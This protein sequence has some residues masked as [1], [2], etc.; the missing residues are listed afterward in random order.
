MGSAIRAASQ[1]AAAEL[2]NAVP[3]RCPSILF[4]PDWRLRSARSIILRY[5]LP[6][7]RLADQGHMPISSGLLCELRMRTERIEPATESG[8]IA[9][10]ATAC[11]ER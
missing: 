1:G 6:V 8:G 11:R 5:G 4:C 2:A 9:T 3:A 7:K 10:Q